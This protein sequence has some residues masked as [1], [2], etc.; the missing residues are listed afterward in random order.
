MLERIVSWD[1]HRSEMFERDDTYL[2]STVPKAETINEVDAR[3]I[4]DRFRRA[5][6][7]APVGDIRV[8]F[9]LM[10]E[11][12]LFALLHYTLLISRPVLAWELDLDNL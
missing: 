3:F 1:L 11:N 9:G 10:P 8:Q 5:M 12:E 6:K 7:K 2:L 4:I